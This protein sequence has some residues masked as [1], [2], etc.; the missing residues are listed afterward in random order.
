MTTRSHTDQPR[1][2]LI[3]DGG[4]TVCQKS[5]DWVSGWDTAGVVECV[6][7]QDPSVAE[8]FPHFSVEA[9]DEEIHLVAPDG[10]VTRGSE[11]VEELLRVT[12]RPPPLA[13]L[14]SLPGGRTAARIGY[15]MF[16][17]NRHRFGCGEHCSLQD[18]ANV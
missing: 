8:R 5:V 18:R 6:P 15:R 2:T 12:D 16:A 13:W 3:F 14:F 9:M 10:A 7:Y 4:C 1:Y 17:R 11:A